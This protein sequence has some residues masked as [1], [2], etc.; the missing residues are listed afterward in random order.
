[1]RKTPL[2]IADPAQW[3]RQLSEDSAGYSHLVKDSKGV[4]RAAYRLARA[5]CSV[6]TGESP[7]LHDLKAAA[8]QLAAHLGAQ[9]SL[10]IESM[11][12]ASVEMSSSRPSRSASCAPS[13]WRAAS[14]PAPTPSPSRAERSV[15]PPAP[16]MRRA[17]SRPQASRASV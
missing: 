11:L 9:I 15:P 13:P 17:K 5:Q 12:P 1:M 2:E 3:L 8:A 7:A 6:E 4:A 10:P 14:T 16:S